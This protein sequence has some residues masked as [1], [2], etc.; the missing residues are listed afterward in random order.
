M[1]LVTAPRKTMPRLC[2]GTTTNFKQ[3]QQWQQCINHKSE[4][5]SFSF[6]SIAEQLPFSTGGMLNESH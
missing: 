6:Q 5:S 1:D 2:L 3:C 4:F